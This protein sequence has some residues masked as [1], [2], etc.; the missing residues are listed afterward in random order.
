MPSSTRII[1]R[2]W[3][4]WTKVE[5][6]EA[7]ERL[8]RTEIIPAIID[9]NVAGLQGIEVLRRP[10]GPSEAE[11]LTVMR[12]ESWEAVREFAGDDYERA[13]VPSS[14]QGLLLRYD[15]RARHYEIVAGR[16]A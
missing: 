10:A 3:H 8:L 6:A 5:N 4:G 14:A 9:R 2:L 7:Y 11:F 16:S 13:V 15:A 1:A 12:F